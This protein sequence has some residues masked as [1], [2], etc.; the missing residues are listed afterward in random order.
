MLFYNHRKIK[1][2][3]IEVHPTENALLVT[4]EVEATI[5]GDLGDPMLGEKKECKKV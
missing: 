4:Y 3:Q 1:G 2:G 5:L